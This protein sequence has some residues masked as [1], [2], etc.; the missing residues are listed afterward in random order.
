MRQAVRV[1]CG[2]GGYVLRT[3]GEEGF[4]VAKL[5]KQNFPFAAALAMMQVHTRMCT[6]MYT[7]MYAH[8]AALAMMQALT[9][10]S[11]R[12]LI[13][14]RTHTHTLILILILTLHPHPHPSSSLAMMPFLPLYMHTYMHTHMHACMH[15]YI[16]TY[17]HTYIHDVV[18]AALHHSAQEAGGRGQ[19]QWKGQKGQ[20]STWWCVSHE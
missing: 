1:L 8:A 11:T 2:T 14:T 6:C 9:P 5:T 16:H 4:D 20:V 15:A 12:T 13:R 18:L 17:I 7:C 10:A 3:V 19:E